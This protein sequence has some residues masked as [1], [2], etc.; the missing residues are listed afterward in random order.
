V[1]RTDWLSV[2]WLYL[3]LG[4]AFL[5]ILGLVTAMLWRARVHRVLRIGQE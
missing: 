4:L 2:G 3:L 5:I 1:P